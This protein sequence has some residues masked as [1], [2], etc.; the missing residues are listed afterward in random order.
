MLFKKATIILVGAPNVGKSALFERLTGTYASV[1]NYPGTTVDITR[2]MA[3][4]GDFWVEFIDTPGTYS[5]LPVTQEE[6]VAVDLVLMQKADALIHVVNASGICRMLPMT[7]DLIETSMPVILDINMIDEAIRD[8]MKIDTQALAAKLGIPVVAT[9][10]VDGTGITNLKAVIQG[11]LAGQISVKPPEFN[12]EIETALNRVAEMLPKKN[13]GVAGR[14]ASLLF[15]R[16]FEAGKPAL[17]ANKPALKKDSPVRWLSLIELQELNRKIAAERQRQISE[18]MPFILTATRGNQENFGRKL[19]RWTRE[20]LTGIP[21]L[22]GVMYFGIYQIVGRLGAG[23]LVDFMDKTV[24][25]RFLDPL[26]AAMLLNF[27][28]PDWLRSLI[29]G[30]YGLFTMGLRYAI[31]IVLPIVGTF[32]LMF[33]VLEDSGYLPRVAML[34]DQVFRRLGLTGRA[35]IPIILG[36]GCGTMAVMATR[37]LG[38]RKERTLATFLLALAVPC[39]AQLGLVLGMLSGDFAAMAI[40]AACMLA[41]IF[42]SGWAGKR[43]IPGCP[44]LFYIEL[45]PMLL[46]L[47]RN[48]AAKVEMRL[49]TYFLALVPLFMLVSLS[50]WVADSM[51]ILALFVQGVAPLMKWIG[52]PPETGEVFLLGFFRRDYGTAGL[53]DL[54]KSGLLDRRQLVVAATAMT[55]FVPCIAQ[56]LIMVKERGL[57]NALIIVVLVGSLAFLLSGILNAILISAEFAG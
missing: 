13:Y 44:G 57:I 14:I 28:A 43:I 20:P 5:L 2:G 39:S 30:E 46:P 22:I 41:A 38:T 42:V 12:Q 11:V 6:K 26:I 55:L 40:W 32:F 8:G 56:F 15:L 34:A 7:L 50:M 35:V 53:Y 48:V 45:P 17:F 21:I 33:A 10:M 27:G 24:C 9:S 19:G 3:Q 31:A 47:W 23:T 16:D 25:G 29:M 49:K 54:A 51:G 4:I 18:L 1:A 37:T 52:L 36:F